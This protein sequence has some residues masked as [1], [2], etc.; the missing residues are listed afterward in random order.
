MHGPKILGHS[1]HP[2]L[3][4]FPLGLLATA[5]VFD[6]LHLLTAQPVF[7][8][9]TER[10][11]VSGLIGGL[12]AALLVWIDWMAIPSHTREKG[13]GL[14]HGLVNSVVLLL[15]LGSWYA[16]S[17]EPAQPEIL[18]TFFSTAGSGLALV[19][20]WIGGELLERLDGSVH[21]KAET[22]PISITS[23]DRPTSVTRTAH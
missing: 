19:G 16:R 14:A 22:G 4:V 6:F 18:A 5:V 7:A 2:A 8:V 9:I 17:N 1:I 21:E 11:M 20:G 12:I 15:F 10:V 13:I 3:I 23:V